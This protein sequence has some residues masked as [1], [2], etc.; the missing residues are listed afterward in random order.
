MAEQ[1]KQYSIFSWNVRGLNSA[2]QQEDVKE[3]VQ[4][5]RP[6]IVCLQETKSQLITQ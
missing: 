5:H 6:M 1:I 4:M 3:I 2:A